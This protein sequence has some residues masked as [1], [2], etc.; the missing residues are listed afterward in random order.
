MKLQVDGKLKG[1]I[2]TV[3]VVLGLLII[4][5][6]IKVVPAGVWRIVVASLGLAIAAIGGYAAKAQVLGLRP[7]GEPAWRKAKRTYVDN[8][9][10]A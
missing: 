7:F 3:L 2:M 6:A 9:D 10:N 8:E 4:F 1:W 5:L